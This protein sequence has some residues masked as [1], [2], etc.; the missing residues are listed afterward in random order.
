MKNVAFW[1][2]SGE[3]LRKMLWDIQSRAARSRGMVIDRFQKECEHTIT[4]EHRGIRGIHMDDGYDP[5]S[6]SK[7][8]CIVC[9][10]IEE[11]R[12]GRGM[13]AVED[14]VV[15]NHWFRIIKTKPHKVVEHQEFEKLSKE[16]FN[17]IPSFW[18]ERLSIAL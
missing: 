16:V 9:G 6:P 18:L 14:P 8:L 5:P 1:L 2:Q 7:R 11:S 12:P 15:W 10:F 3:K 13:F 17:S 4:V